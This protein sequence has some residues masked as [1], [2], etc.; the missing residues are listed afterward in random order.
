MMRW[1]LRSLP[2]AGFEGAGDASAY[3]MEI[4]KLLA[5]I[6]ALLTSVGIGR[7]KT[8]L[9]IHRPAKAGLQKVGTSRTRHRYYQTKKDLV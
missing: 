3:S 5:M 1:S 6:E 4:R 7:L 8:R 9:L 2:Q